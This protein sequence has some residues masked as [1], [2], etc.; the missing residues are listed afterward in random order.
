MP[1]LLAFTCSCARPQRFVHMDLAARNCLLHTGEPALRA[2]GPLT[3]P[4]SALWIGR[5]APFA[6]FRAL[7][8]LLQIHL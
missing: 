5:R 4:P 3:F 6:S 2:S 8:R 7:L 1:L